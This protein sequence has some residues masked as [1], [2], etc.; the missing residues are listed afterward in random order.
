MTDNFEP[1]PKIVFAVSLGCPKNL[2]DTEVMLGALAGNGYE[3]ASDPDVAD[4]IIVNTCGFISDA[5]SESRTTIEEMTKICDQKPDAL[6]IVAGCLAEREKENLKAD[7]PRID[8]LIGTSSYADIAAII[9]KRK[10]SSFAPQTFMHDHTHPRLL[11][12]MPWTAYLKIA[13]GCSNRCSYCLIPSLRGPLRSREPESLVREARDL[14]SIGVRELIVVAQDITR[15][16]YERGEKDALAE[17]LPRLADIDGIHWIRLMYAYPDMIDRKLA[18]TIGEI[19]RVCKYLDMPV[20]HIDDDILKA[21]NRHGGSDAIRRAVDVLRSEVPGISLRTTV[22][23]GFPGET[24]EQFQRLLRF[25]EQTGF[26]RLGAFAYS[27]EKGTPAAGMSGI[28]DEELRNRRRDTI[29]QVQ[30]E[31]SL[32]INR[33]LIGGRVEVLVEDVEETEDGD[34][35]FSGRSGRDAPH[36]D[37]CVYFDGDAEQGD[38]VC[39]EIDNAD[40]YDLEGSVI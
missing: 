39:V 13:E 34:I 21:M 28:P 3:I 25:I 14:A 30:Q 5:V 4:I 17:L 10:V 36:I 15:Y 38:F 22:I 26:D 2:V 35:I 1:E 8:M 18:K 29:M 32:Y 6:L 11:A 19:D 31:I 16:G 7:F 27:P 40:E 9:E 33:E 37:G 23:A 20:Q 12:T 24:D